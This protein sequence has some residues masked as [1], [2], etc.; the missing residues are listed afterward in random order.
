MRRKHPC[1]DCRC[2]GCEDTPADASVSLTD[3]A[4][5]A[6]Q[7]DALP[8]GE[9]TGTLVAFSNATV[10]WK[11][12]LRVRVPGKADSSRNDEDTNAERLVEEG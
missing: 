8:V 2:I 6:A 3:A 12:F 10:N 5:T 1:M 11:G 7:A 9:H 4:N